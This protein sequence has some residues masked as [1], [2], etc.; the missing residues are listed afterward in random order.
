MGNGK[1]S[2]KEFGMLPFVDPFNDDKKKVA[3]VSKGWALDVV[4]LIGVV[5]VGVFIAYVF[6][7]AV[8]TPRLVVAI[9]CVCFALPALL[10]FLDVTMAGSHGLPATYFM[11]WKWIS[12]PS[13]LVFIGAVIWCSF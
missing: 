10:R 8:P 12:A 5:V 2:K 4:M 9:S 7:S 11:R 1:T 6:Q 3:D 13:A